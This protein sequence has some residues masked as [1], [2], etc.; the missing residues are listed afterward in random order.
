MKITTSKEIIRKLCNP[1]VAILFRH[2]ITVRQLY[3]LLY[4]FDI[5]SN[6]QLFILIDARRYDEYSTSH[7][8][9]SINIPFNPKLNIAQTLLQD[10]NIPIVVYCGLGLRSSLLA[11][12]LK[13]KGYKNIFV[14]KGAFYKWANLGYTLCNLCCNC[15]KTVQPHNLP[16]RLIIKTTVHYQSQ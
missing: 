2:H 11:K 3:C 7:I 5:A 15:V 16:A 1:F 10:M 9:G 8:K 13:R 14:L 6:I 4:N 12:K